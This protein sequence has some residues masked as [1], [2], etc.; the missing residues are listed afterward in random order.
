MH[1][2]LLDKTTADHDSYLRVAM[3]RQRA[4]LFV[5]RLGWTGL[6]VT[7][8]GEYDDT[9]ND[10]D[11]S[12]L[13]TWDRSGIIGSCRLVP[14]A[15]NSLLA[16]PL[17]NYLDTPVAANTQAWELTR[18][19]PA[20]DPNDPRHSLSFGVLA[21]GILAFSALRNVP[22]IFG[23]A[24]PPLV[25]IATSLGC[26]IAIE[27]PPVEYLPGMKAFAFSFPID[28]ETNASV[29]RAL[30]RDKVEFTP[31]RTAISLIGEAA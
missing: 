26:K 31:V 29:L 6:H 24:E 28:A 20:T 15:G 30:R 7:E 3:H 5:S 12:Y 8:D 22:H 21:G 1:I 9:D 11:A 23:I 19:A 14:L 13:V 4:D 2:S 10:P 16:G 25:G 18:Y 17:A 27:G